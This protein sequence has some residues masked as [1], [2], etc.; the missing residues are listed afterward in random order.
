MVKILLASMSFCCYCCWLCCCCGQD[1]NW[2]I[3]WPTLAGHLNDADDVTEFGQQIWRDKCKP[4]CNW[5]NSGIQFSLFTS[6]CSYPIVVS[7][8]TH[9]LCGSSSSMITH[10]HTHTQCSLTVL[11]AD[12][13]PTDATNQ[14]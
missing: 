8:T 9:C 2:I 1:S 14:V 5:Q 10:R 4:V 7:L 11:C 12:Q 3:S 6:C 13:Q